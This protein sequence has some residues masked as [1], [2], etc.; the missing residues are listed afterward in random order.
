M[1]GTRE[2][3]TPLSN[4]IGLHTQSPSGISRGA[5][6]VIAAFAARNNY[7]EMRFGNS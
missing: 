7:E 3:V 1:G 6:S 2:K 4:G 5:R